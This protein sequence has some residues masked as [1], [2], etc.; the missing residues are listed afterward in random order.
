VKLVVSKEALGDIERLRTF[1]DE[2]EE[3][4]EQ[5]AVAVLRRAVGSLEIF[6]GR[7]R[8]SGIPGVRELVV[9]FGHSAYLVRYFHDRERETVV[10]I[11]VWHEREA[12]E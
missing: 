3:A 6:P 2:K 5:H 10:V 4:A 9:P 1:L 12:R 7:G 11:R 8:P